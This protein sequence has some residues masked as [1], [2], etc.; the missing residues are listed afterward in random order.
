MDPKLR[1]QMNESKVGEEIRKAGNSLAK[2][3]DGQKEAPAGPHERTYI[4]SVFAQILAELQTDPA[5]ADLTMADL[6]AVLWYAEKRLYESAKDNNVDQESTGRSLE[7][8]RPK[9]EAL[10]KEKNG[11]SQAPSQPELQDPIEAAIRNNPGLTRQ[12][13]VEMAEK[14]GF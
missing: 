10:L 8:S 1:E 7:G 12:K 5:Y 4:R 11:S 13:A 14:F 2:Y 3:N 9:L 6:Q